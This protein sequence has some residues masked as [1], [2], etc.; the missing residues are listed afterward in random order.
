ME[1]QILALLLL[2]LKVLLVSQRFSERKARISSGI[3]SETFGMDIFHST[4]KIDIYPQTDLR[5]VTHEVFF[6]ERSFVM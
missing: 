5:T 3:M 4:V 1:I 2:N 6:I